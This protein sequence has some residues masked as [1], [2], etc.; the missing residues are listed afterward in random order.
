MQ[1]KITVLFCWKMKHN[2]FHLLFFFYIK[3]ICKHCRTLL[4]KIIIVLKYYYI[5]LYYGRTSYIM[6]YFSISF[7]SSGKR[8]RFIFVLTDLGQV[9]TA[10]PRC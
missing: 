4:P 10:R 2:C 6:G 8:L 9:N 1:Y 7:L 3:Q 5:L